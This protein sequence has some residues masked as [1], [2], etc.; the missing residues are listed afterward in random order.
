[1]KKQNENKNYS[2]LGLSTFSFITATSLFNAG[3]DVLV[4]D[5][6]PQ[7]IQKISDLVTKAVCG[8]VLD[9]D[10]LDHLG[11]PQTDVAI[12]GLKDN[13]DTAILVIN[14]LK[15]SK[16]GQ[17]I[18]QVDNEEKA[19][20]VK[21]LGATKVAFPEKD[22][23]EYVVKS[24]LFPSKLEQFNFGTDAGIIEITCPKSFVGKTMIDLQIRQRFNVYIIGIQRL[25]RT[26]S[27]THIQT[28]LLPQPNTPFKEE[29]NLIVIGKL[30]DLVKLT[31]KMKI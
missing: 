13:F 31:E 16:I 8:D 10:L 7:K 22:S 29:D 20:I 28:T 27:L 24:L 25:E 15:S 12:V 14:Y 19:T 30:E 3:M 5:K 17:I 26:K 2:I 18:A 9:Y 1:M 6:D 23:A 4:V 11:V 21:L